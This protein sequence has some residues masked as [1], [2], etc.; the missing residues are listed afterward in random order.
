M[1]EKES[2][3]NPLDKI[4]LGKSVAGAILTKEALPM[5][6]LETFD[7]AGIYSIFYRGGFQPYTRLTDINR[8]SFERPIYV[9]KAVPEGARKGA[10]GLD[11]MSGTFL[12]KRLND[13]K[14]SILQASNLKESDFWVRYLVVD[15]IWI[16]LGESLMIEMF[17]PL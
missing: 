10:G 16:P 13:H 12:F 2:P 7:G 17:R 11:S 6:S 15:D 8:N 1:S 5:E 3:Y 4:N 9:G 14:K